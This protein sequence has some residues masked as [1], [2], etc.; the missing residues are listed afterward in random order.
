MTGH[1]DKSN[2]QLAPCRWNLASNGIK[3]DSYYSLNL[4]LILVKIF[5]IVELYLQ[6]QLLNKVIIAFSIKL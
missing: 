1:L 3:C 2:L 6:Y 5:R 4:R